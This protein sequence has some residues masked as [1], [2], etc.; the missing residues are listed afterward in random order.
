MAGAFGYEAEH[1]DLSMR[2]GE[3]TLFPA[4]RQENESVLIAAAGVSCRAQ[5]ED[6]T[7][8]K[9]FHPIQLIDRVLLGGDTG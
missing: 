2:V 4:I 5:I 8:R 1:Y 7:G 6:G 3:L 9:P